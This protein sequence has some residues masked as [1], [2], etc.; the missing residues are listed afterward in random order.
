MCKYVLDERVVNLPLPAMEALLRSEKLQLKSENV[1]FSLA[2]W[3]TMGQPG[4]KKERQSMFTRMLKSMRYARMS[5]V[6]LAS[7]ADLHFSGLR[8]APG[9]RGSGILAAG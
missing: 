4:A 3:W 8:A 2:L 5:S 6:F 7:I 1:T 9:H